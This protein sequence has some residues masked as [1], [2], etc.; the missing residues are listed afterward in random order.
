MLLNRF[1]AWSLILFSMLCILCHAVELEQAFPIEF[2]L[3]PNY[4]GTK[5]SIIR[6]NTSEL[7][8][9]INREAY[10]TIDRARD[11]LVELQSTNGM[12][13]TNDGDETLLPALALF[14]GYTPSPFYSNKLERAISA[15]QDWLKVNANKPWSKKQTKEAAITINLLAL[16]KQTDTVPPAAIDHLKNISP[17]T[18]HQLDPI[19]KYFLIIALAQLNELTLTS[20]DTIIREQA[21]VDKNDLLPISI[22]GISRLMRAKTD[23]PTNDAK[24]YLRFLSSKL[25]LGYHNPSPD[26]EVLS[27][28]LAFLTTIFASSFTN[29]QL[30]LDTTLFPYDWRNHLANRIIATQIYCSETGAPYWKENAGEDEVRSSYNALEATSLAIITLTNLA[31]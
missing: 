30:A 20:F 18:L 28:Q 24:A 4:I 7:P 10:A 31:N 23:T 2:A 27:P 15:A 19:G 13:K 29:R 12:W 25:Q 22:I 26:N 6:S 9:S 5:I 11:A 16:S 3:T 21:S 1:G 8:E 14:D 17:A